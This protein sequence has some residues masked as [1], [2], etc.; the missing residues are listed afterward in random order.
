MNI[1][2]VDEARL[3]DNGIDFGRVY[4]DPFGG[5]NQAKI[6]DLGDMEGIFSDVYL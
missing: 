5:N 4:L 1:F 2:D 6:G 3:I